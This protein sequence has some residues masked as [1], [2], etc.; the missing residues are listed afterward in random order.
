VLDELAALIVRLDGVQLVGS[1]IAAHLFE[2]SH[3]DAKCA[4]ATAFALALGKRLQRYL[5]HPVAASE[6]S[7]NVGSVS[8]GADGVGPRG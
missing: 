3:C 2:V 1:D 5:E 8:D 7:G 4:D 6:A